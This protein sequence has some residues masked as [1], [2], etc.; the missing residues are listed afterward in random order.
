MMF[1][2]ISATVTMLQIHIINLF[3]THYIAVNLRNKLILKNSV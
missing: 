3:E 2:V 1:Y